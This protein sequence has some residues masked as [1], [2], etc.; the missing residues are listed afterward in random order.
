MEELEF[1]ISDGNL[2]VGYDVFPLSKITVVRICKSATKEDQYAIKI[3]MN[4]A[5]SMELNYSTYNPVELDWNFSRLCEAIR[6]EQA[7]YHVYDD[8][9]MINVGNIEHITPVKVIMGRKAVNVSFNERGRVV[10]LPYIKSEYIN[11]VEA[12]HQYQEKKQNAI[13]A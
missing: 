10:N 4:D 5:M 1:K 2:Y 13:N 11:L 12:H 8:D 7:D 9:Y 6:E 3:M